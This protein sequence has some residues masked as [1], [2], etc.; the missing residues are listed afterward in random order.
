MS[1]VVYSDQDVAD[2]AGVHPSACQ[3]HPDGQL[4]CYLQF[5]RWKDGTYHDEP[6]STLMHEKY[7]ACKKSGRH[8]INVWGEC[9]SC[10][11]TEL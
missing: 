5:W 4:V 3:V 11:S 9:T 1:D 10:G 7:L 6:E 8:Y 2:K